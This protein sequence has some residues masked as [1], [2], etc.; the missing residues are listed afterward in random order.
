MS[1]VRVSLPR[2]ITLSIGVLALA[3]AL[4]G[5]SRTDATTMDR[6]RAE[7]D[8]TTGRLRRLTFDADRNGRNNA[9]SV[10]DGTRIER[11]EVDTDENGTVDHWAYYDDQRRL[12]KVGVSRQNDGIIDAFEVYDQTDRT[13]ETVAR[14]EVS[15]RRDNR[16]DRVE[17]YTGGVLAR[18]EADTN[19]DGRVDKWETYRPV[20]NRAAGDP[21]SSISSV[22]FD[23]AHRGAPT[24]ILVFA[25]DGSVE[26]IEIDPDGDGVF[27]AQ[28]PGTRGR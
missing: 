27:T 19:A 2:L 21:P 8:S 13:D 3:N 26:R 22:A 12:V 5:C 16:F 10:M 15:T 28:E 23:D 6:P 7:Y 24:R 1:R 20:G 18:V 17:F 11:I 14:I 25:D 9:V 4:A